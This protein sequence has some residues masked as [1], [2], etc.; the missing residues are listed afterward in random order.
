MKN[1]FRTAIGILMVSLTVSCTEK[2]ETGIETSPKDPNVEFTSPA[3]VSATQAS[4]PAPVGTEQAAE[5]SAKNT[6]PI[7]TVALSGPHFD[8]GNIKKGEK[9]SHTYEFTNT[10]K[11]PLIISDVRPGCG[12]TAPEFT[13][14][15]IAPGKT[16]KVTLSF[17]SSQFEGPVSKEANVFANVEKSPIRLTFNA[18]IQSK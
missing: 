6:G 14:E 8:F 18:N 9:V 3:Q 15:P 10:G 2:K 13:K 12:C 5:K 4:S 11:I 7:T 17:D 1:N 16:G